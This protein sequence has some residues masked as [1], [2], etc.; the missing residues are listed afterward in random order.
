[1]EWF[2]FAAVG[3]IAL[4][5]TVAATPLV[6]RLAWR[7]GA[8]DYPDGRRINTR[9]IPRLGGVAVFIGLSLAL[10]FVV[11]VNGLYPDLLDI[12]GL[13]RDINYYGVGVALFVMFAIGLI[14]DLYQIKPIIKFLGQC[15]AAIIACASGVLFSHFLNPLGSGVIDI[16]IVAYPFTVF[17]LVAFANI[18]NLIDGLDGLASGLVAICAAALFFLSFSRGGMDAAIVA[19]ALIGA[20]VGFLFFNFYP[21][22]VFLGD[23]G[24]L[25]LGFS[26]GLVSLFG[27]VRATA[28]VSLLIPVVIAGIPVIDTFTSIVRRLRS[29]QSVFSADK[30]H[31][32]H[33]FI[34]L[35]FSQR[36]TVLIIYGLSI[37]LALLAILIVQD[38]SPLRIVYILIVIVVVALFIWRLGLMSTVLA[39]HYEKRKSHAQQQMRK[40]ESEQQDTEEG[41]SGEDGAP[42]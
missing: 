21:A 19:I 18:I 12:R 22:R 42:K 5:G 3:L 17:Y 6:M 28:L 35:G 4:V 25:L 32:H 30:E 40:E 31:A 24:A 39:H 34:N 2:W 14:D 37:V 15:V 7:V 23:S 41:S 38:Q 10:G 20:C 8:I 11:V 33:R 16:G 26:L 29:G 9:P 27:V 1:M 13:N 36:T